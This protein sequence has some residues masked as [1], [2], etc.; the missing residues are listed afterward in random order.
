[1]AYNITLL[2][3]PKAKIQPEP[4]ALLSCIPIPKR[5]LPKTKDKE[6]GANSKLLG[7]K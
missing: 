3:V 1:M 5:I 7:V 6:I 2:P 4:Q